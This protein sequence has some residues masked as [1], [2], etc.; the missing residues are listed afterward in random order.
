MVLFLSC[1]RRILV[2]HYITANCGKKK[3]VKT[4]TG[5]TTGSYASCIIA[6]YAGNAEYAIGGRSYG[7]SKIEANG[8]TLR[9]MYLYSMKQAP[10]SLRNIPIAITQLLWHKNFILDDL[11]FTYL[12]VTGTKNSAC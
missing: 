3:K 11:W 7:I 10:C 4:L 1:Y 6:H 5:G 8:A 9:E 12:H 2:R